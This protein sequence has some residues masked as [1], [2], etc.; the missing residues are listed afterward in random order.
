MQKILIGAAVLLS[1]SLTG[2]IST[3]VH[4]SKDGSVKTTTTAVRGCGNPSQTITRVETKGKADITFGSTGSDLCTVVAG[5]AVS[6][7]GQV[8][9]SH[10]LPGSN[11][12]VSS[13]SVNESNTDVD[14][15]TN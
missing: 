6:A 13:G 4:V 5:S 2:C 7:A 14:I 11:I 12:N 9:A 10:V 1:V 3:Q 8:L 15:V